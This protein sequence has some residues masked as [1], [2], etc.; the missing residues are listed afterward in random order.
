M[1]GV[2]FVQV[3]V[4]VP[5]DPSDRL[6]RDYAH[7]PDPKQLN[8]DFFQRPG[9]ISR[10]WVLEVKVREQLC[11]SILDITMHCRKSDQKRHGINKVWLTILV[12]V[13][14][15]HAINIFYRL[16]VKE[17]NAKR[18]YLTATLDE[19]SNEGHPCQDL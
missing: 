12:Q 10:K 15:R 9:Y 16:R 6:L 18:N 1:Y 5:G 3:N 19:I 2:E 8:P 4:T 7:D 17:T 13:V 11:Y 14:I